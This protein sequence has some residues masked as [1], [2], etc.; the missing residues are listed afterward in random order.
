MGST[1]THHSQCGRQIWWLEF[2]DLVLH[3]EKRLRAAQRTMYRSGESVG[4]TTDQDPDSCKFFFVDV[5]LQGNTA[6]VLPHCCDASTDD[7]DTDQ[8]NAL[9][10]QVNQLAAGLADVDK[11]VAALTSLLTDQLANTA[12][13]TPENIGSVS[14]TTGAALGVSSQRGL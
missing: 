4:D 11:E 12:P 5:A 2:A 10:T 7:D 6:V 3:Y 13:L 8:E 1:F 9:Q 14:P